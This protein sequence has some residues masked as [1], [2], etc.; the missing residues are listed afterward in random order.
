MPTFGEETFYTPEQVAKKLQLS[1]TTVYNLIRARKIPSL[2]IGKS[3]R[4]P[5]SG[6][7]RLWAK[8]GPVI[9]QTALNFV[10]MLKKAPFSGKIADVVLFG[11]YARGEPHDDSDIDLLLIYTGLSEGELDD[12]LGMET[13]AMESTDYIDDISVMKKT[14]E[15]WG[16]LGRMGAGIYE[17]V[18]SEGVSLWKSNPPKN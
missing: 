15:K 13:D 10:D 5:E 11:S 16:R 2:Q 9:P 12:I 17:N 18:T 1:L 8:K 14:V 3:F 4:I 6:L 7:N